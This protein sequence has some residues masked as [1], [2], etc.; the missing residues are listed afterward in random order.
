MRRF[1]T[2]ATAMAMALMMLVS[3]VP[4]ASA[5]TPFCGIHW[6][7]RPKAGSAHPDSPIVAARAG[8]HACYD[9]LVLEV[10]GSAPGYRVEYVDTFVPDASGRT[11]SL[12]GGAQ[13]QI[14]TLGVATP[15][16]GA[17][18]PARRTEMLPVDGYRTFRQAYWGGVF[19]GTA[20]VGLGVR[21][22]LPF[23]VF[24]L[25]G[26][27]SNSRLVIDVAHRW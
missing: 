27:G 20:V 4:A 25:A 7:S 3:L 16:A 10:R 14:T 12:R 2:L 13:L 19:E 9:R 22:R 18:S 15:G 6:G 11:V 1:T 23:R 21:A 24:T 5:A 8:R 26:P 17:W